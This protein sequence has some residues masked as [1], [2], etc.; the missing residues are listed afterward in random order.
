QHVASRGLESFDVRSVMGCGGGVTNEL[1]Q[2]FT[3][4]NDG[5]DLD[6]TFSFTI[7]RDSANGFEQA[8]KE[9]YRC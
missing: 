9:A 2:I 6:P 5:M 8:A 3:R 1:W 4:I 7:D